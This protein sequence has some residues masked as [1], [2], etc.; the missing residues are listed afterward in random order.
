MLAPLLLAAALQTGLSAPQPLTEAEVRALNAPVEPVRRSPPLSTEEAERLS[1]RELAD[2]GFGELSDSV[3][4]VWRPGGLGAG[5]ALSS[6]DLML[7]PTGGAIGGLCRSTEVTVRFGRE[8]G[9]GTPPGSSEGRDAPRRA[10]D[11]MSRRIFKVAGPL[12]RLKTVEA[13]YAWDA[14]CARR[15]DVKSF[16]VTNLPD[17]DKLIPALIGI[18]QALE[19]RRR[20]MGAKADLFPLPPSVGGDVR[21]FALE[22]VSAVRGIAAGDRIASLEVI[23]APGGVDGGF[24]AKMTIRDVAWRWPAFDSPDYGVPSVTIGSV[25]VEPHQVVYD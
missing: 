5:V 7:Q 10:E 14:A 2:R 16:M 11:V 19:Q 9:P 6:V 15:R 1:V 24:G 25:A 20:A 4:A 12:R 23:F 13:E 18:E 22:N 21:I 17:E 8:Q 3:V